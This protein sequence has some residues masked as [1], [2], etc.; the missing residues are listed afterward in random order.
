MSKFIPY[1]LLIFLCIN[2][3]CGQFNNPVEPT[4][5]LNCYYRKDGFEILI[6]PSKVEIQCSDGFYV[7]T[8]IGNTI[9]TLYLKTNTDFSK[10]YPLLDEENSTFIYKAILDSVDSNKIYYTIVLLS[11]KD[12]TT[13][14]S[15]YSNADGDRCIEIAL[16]NEIMGHPKQFLWQTR[17]KQ[18]A[19]YVLP[20]E[21]Y[22]YIVSASDIK[23]RICKHFYRII[24]K[25]KEEGLITL[26]D[27][28]LYKNRFRK[29]RR[30]PDRFDIVFFLCPG[31]YIVKKF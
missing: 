18:N 27:S 10:K 22:A 15:Y 6:M 30:G 8:N 3:Y 19:I 20:P 1:I 2:F 11:T 23:T 7:T 4:H 17:V 28:W 5:T 13:D 12:N 29:I 24:N 9:V 14:T 26:S 16:N 31:H 21:P 25:E